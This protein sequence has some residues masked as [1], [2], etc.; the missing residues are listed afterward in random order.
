M[1]YTVEV[2]PKIFL[3]TQIVYSNDVITT[4]I[5]RNERKLPVHWS[6]KVSKRY[7]R[8][9]II[10]DLNRATRITSFP[11]DEIPKIKQKFLNADYPH[12]FINSVINNFQE[13]SEETENY[14][15]PPGFFDVP[16]KVVLVDIPY[17]PK[18]E[19]FSKRFMKK[20]DVFTDNKY[21]ISIKW[22]AKKFKQL[23]KLNCRNPHPSR[24][25]YV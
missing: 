16:K 21:D 18:N 23:F 22:I 24:V 2:N 8:N 25:I 17:C 1:K 4:E 7:K 13:K 11:A 12:R 19:E 5:K 10:S 6:S 14:I 9:T 20:F 3:D 15:T